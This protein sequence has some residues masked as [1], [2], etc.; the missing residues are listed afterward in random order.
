MRCFCKN[1]S[2]L[3]TFYWYL[4][5]AY[6][7]YF[8]WIR[9]HNWF[10][11]VIYS[12]LAAYF[13]LGNSFEGHVCMKSNVNWSDIRSYRATL[14]LNWKTSFQ[15]EYSGWKFSTLTLNHLQLKKQTVKTKFFV[16]MNLTYIVCTNFR[17]W[18]VLV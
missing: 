8:L 11:T 3:S 2:I 16:S 17:F 15:L 7:P 13:E 14:V 6:F 4:N 1:L 18:F 5:R 12:T 10:V 9:T